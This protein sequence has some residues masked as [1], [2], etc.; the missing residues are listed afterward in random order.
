ME[1][2]NNDEN[3]WNFTKIVKHNAKVYYKLINCI[4]NYESFWK[5]N[6]I[7]S[8]CIEKLVYFKENWTKMALKW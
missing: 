7:H 2:Y 6:T 3:Y 1:S 5:C 8:K 4:R